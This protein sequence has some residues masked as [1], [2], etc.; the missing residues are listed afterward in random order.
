MSK[1]CKCHILNLCFGFCYTE[2][3]VSQLEPQQ[4]S[5]HQQA[6]HGKDNLSAMDD[7][8]GLGSNDGDSEGWQG[9]DESFD[10]DGS[11]LLAS[12]VQEH[13]SASVWGVGHAW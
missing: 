6:F 8:L 11:E 7:W 13:S 1:V 2:L 3:Q 5:N 4:P 9:Q 12:Q 10:F